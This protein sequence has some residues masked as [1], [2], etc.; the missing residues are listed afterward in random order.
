METLARVGHRRLVFGTD[1]MGHHPA[2][3][4]GRLLSLDVPDEIFL[5]ILGGTMREILSRRR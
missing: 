3:E 5:P 4:M 2:W 1:A